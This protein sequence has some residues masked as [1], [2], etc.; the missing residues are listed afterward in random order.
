MKSLKCSDL[1]A[2]PECSFEA[3]GEDNKETIDAMYTHA[4]EAHPEKMSA[5]GK[6]DHI[7]IQQKMNEMLDKQK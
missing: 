1:G 7:A 4:K 6:E 5:M 3:T 2:N